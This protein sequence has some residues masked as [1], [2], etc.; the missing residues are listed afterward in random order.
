MTINRIYVGEVARAAALRDH[1]TT[2]WQSIQAAHSA[3]TARVWRVA[4]R[5]MKGLRGIPVDGRSR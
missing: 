2:Y 5:W 3:P 4:L 1:V